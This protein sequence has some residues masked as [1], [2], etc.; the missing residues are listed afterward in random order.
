MIEADILRE[1]QDLGDCEFFPL[2]SFMLKV[3]AVGKRRGLE[4]QKARSAE[5]FITLRSV[6]VTQ[7]DRLLLRMEGKPRKCGALPW[8][9]AHTSSEL[10]GAS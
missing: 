1:S 6:D 3:L 8:R 4:R 2:F 5:G 7:R 9:L 10:P